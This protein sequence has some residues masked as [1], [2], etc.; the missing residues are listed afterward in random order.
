[1]GNV[2]LSP[3]NGLIVILGCI[4]SD[5]ELTNL[6]TTTGY[7]LRLVR[8]S[9]ELLQVARSVSPEVLLI[10]VTT[11]HFNFEVSR[12]LKQDPLTAVVSLLVISTAT[13]REDR[14]SA[15]QC[16]VDDYIVAPFDHD[17]LLIRIRNAAVRT[18]QARELKHDKVRIRQLEEARGE[19]TQLIVH[20]MKTPL[21]SL[22]DLLEVA[23]RTASSHFKTDASRFVND[24][25][26]A[27]ETLEELIEFLISVRKMMAGEDLPDK[28]P[29]DILQLSGQISEA[30]SESAQAVG[31]TLAVEGDGSTVLCDKSQMT[32]VI[33]HLIRMA[34]KSNPVEHHVKIRI[35][36]V[37]QTIKLMVVCAGG[38]VDSSVETDALGLTYC[39]LVAT[40]HGGEFGGPLLTGNSTYWWIALPEAIGVNKPSGAVDRGAPVALER[41]RRYLGTLPEKGADLK[42]RSLFSLGTRQQFIIAVSLMSVIPLLAFAYVMGN[43]ILTRSLDLETLYFLLPSTVALIAL[44]V[45]LLARHTLEV[46]HLRNYLEEISRGGAPRLTGHHSSADFVAI[47]RSLGAVINQGTEKV[48]VIEAQSK[49]LLQ[50]EQQRVMSETVG[51]ACHHL[52][53]PATIIRGYLELMKRAEVSP[54]MRVMIQECQAATEDVATVLN[55]L[56]GVDQYETE[57]YLSANEERVGRVDE[58]ILKI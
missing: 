42:K 13:T 4:R 29:C 31:K 23:G 17:D 9:E 24:A 48:K 56:K 34:I 38:A 46:S 58:R 5:C 30:L 8:S 21:T 11:D 35:E 16:G 40:A 15:I 28:R 54:E 10:N 27:T 53:Q 1:M 37:A 6:L 14:V 26:G 7:K 20:D 19:L 18:R 2:M 51:A 22:A 47:Q 39:R 57:P 45:M 41:S 44:G 36:R 50:A 25:L 49:A 3:E 55:R 32:R 33:R 52:G 12:L 43:A